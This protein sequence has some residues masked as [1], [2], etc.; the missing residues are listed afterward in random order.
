M[1]ER[2]RLDGPLLSR[3]T[4]PLLQ[5]RLR[6]QLHRRKTERFQRLLHTNEN[7][8]GLRL[9]PWLRAICNSAATQGAFWTL[10]RSDLISVAAAAAQDSTV[11][12]V[13][14]RRDNVWG[15]GNMTHSDK[16]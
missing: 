7:R 4:R 13:A 6:R 5:R 15:D 3:S 2:R 11:Q 9:P 12:P 8:L 10:W 14:R 1:P 16:S